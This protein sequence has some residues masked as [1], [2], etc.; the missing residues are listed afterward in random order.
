L[1]RV[2]Y[3][4]E[5][6][7]KIVP[8]PPGAD[9]AE[10]ESRNLRHLFIALSENVSDLAI[11]VDR[12][13]RRTW[14]NPAC[15]RVLGYGAEELVGSHAF[16]E[17]RPE[18][19]QAAVEALQL[20]ITEGSVQEASY[21]M[22]TK[23]GAWA[24]LR[25]HFIPIAGLSGGTESVL[26]L[27]QDRTEL[28]AREEALTEAQAHAQAARLAEGMAR[29]YDQILTGALGSLAEAKNAI[30]PH[31]PAAARLE[32]VERA[33]KRSRDLTEQMLAVA[34]VQNEAKARVAL[35]E[36]VR[37]AVGAVLRG[38][39]VRAEYIFPRHLPEV[40]L[41]AEAFAHA[42]RNI[43]TNSVQAMDHGVI[44]LTAEFIP[45]DECAAR[46]HLALRPGAHLALHIQDQGRGMS[47]QVAARAFEP[48]FT[49]RPG[50]QGLGLTTALSTIRRHGG[51]MRLDSTTGVG[52]SISLYLPV[53]AAATGSNVAPTAA[54][55]ARILLMDDEQVVL[56]IL[57]R[58]LGHLG[59]EVTTCT[60]GAQAIAAFTQA[61][62]SNE[63]FDLV[64]LDLV[65]PHG[66][67]GEAAIHTI[68]Q[69]DPAA[70]VIASSA[71]I[72][73]PA[74]RNCRNYG[75]LATLEKPYKVEQL[76]KVIAS[77]LPATK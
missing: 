56:D 51:T 34:P 36:P 10:G 41:D 74:M 31:H 46:S 20:A 17:A 72:D 16:T 63:P 24:K 30:G 28:H 11:L 9:L 57:G 73:H 66:V 45:A 23:S 65:I 70:K 6:P 26:L 33:L 5:P 4:L 21:A 64:L 59:Y 35:E 48:Y 54:H 60:D 69:I 40:D 7:S 76:Q 22:R 1:G 27:A 53:P 32:E 55:R 68:R 8:F 49:T 62:E 75:F 67:G 52:T 13:G 71:K 2:A 12:Q 42:L 77:A 29:E 25:T 19:R 43:V 61:K 44:R 58:M 18:D 37:A 15:C 14:T 39:M 3:E 47:E 50:Q 38:T